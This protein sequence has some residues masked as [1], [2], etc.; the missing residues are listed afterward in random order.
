MNEQCRSHGPQV[1]LGAQEERWEETRRANEAGWTAEA[2]Y[3]SIWRSV[4]YNMLGAYLHRGV[5][6]EAIMQKEAHELNKQ[7]DL[8]RLE[9]AP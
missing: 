1:A 3:G 6:P 2:R 9:R 4:A 7:Y 8:E 5:T